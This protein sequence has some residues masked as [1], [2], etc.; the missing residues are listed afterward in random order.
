MAERSG[1]GVA[2]AGA[3]S[4][5]DLSDTDL[6]ATPLATSAEQAAATAR[7]WKGFAAG[8]NADRQSG[9]RHE[10]ARNAAHADAVP[11]PELFARYGGEDS[12]ASESS[13]DADEPKRDPRNIPELQ[14]AAQDAFVRTAAN[15]RAARLAF[16]AAA[17]PSDI[18]A[19]GF[20]VEPAEGPVA[21]DPS[22]RIDYCIFCYHGPH[23][24]NHEVSRGAAEAAG[25]PA[26]HRSASPPVRTSAERGPADQVRV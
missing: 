11:E 19:D 1:R 17:P 26:S 8:K 3:G 14:R 7:N 21:A 20:D 2:D 10:L 16:A 18:D 6:L 12:A 13:G 9:L 4:S 5:D 15:P 25:I 24:L 22:L 23:L